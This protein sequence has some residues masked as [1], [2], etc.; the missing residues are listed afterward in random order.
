MHIFLQ[1]NILSLRDGS[2]NAEANNSPFISTSINPQFSFLEAF[3]V[4]INL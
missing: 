1:V 4:V 3:N 2:K